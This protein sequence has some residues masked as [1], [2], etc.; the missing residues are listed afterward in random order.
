MSITSAKVGDIFRRGSDY[1]S[2]ND[3]V[4]TSI[5]IINSAPFV[6]Y[7]YVNKAGEVTLQSHAGC[8]FFFDLLNRHGF[9]EAEEN[10]AKPKRA[11]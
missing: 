1:R 3:I 11:A 9:T 5:Y 6:D 8:L 2:G 4:V 10:R 7:N